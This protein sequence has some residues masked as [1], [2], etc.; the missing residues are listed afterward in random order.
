ME[1]V[2]LSA[3]KFKLWLQLTSEMVQVMLHGMNGQTTL[4]STANHL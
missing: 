1:I 3:K 2:V 4:I